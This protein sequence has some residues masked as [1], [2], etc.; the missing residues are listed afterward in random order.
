LRTRMNTD[1]AVD[2]LELFEHV[3]AEP[4]PQL[5]EQRAQLAAEMAAEA[6]N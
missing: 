6:G 2:P 3:F 5:R 4:T 1:P